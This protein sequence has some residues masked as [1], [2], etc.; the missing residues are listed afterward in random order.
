MFLSLLLRFVITSFSFLLSWN[1]DWICLPVSMTD[2][3]DLPYFSL[4]WNFD[5]LCLSVSITDLYNFFNLLVFIFV[6]TEILTDYVH[7][8]QLQIY[9]TCLIYSFLFSLSLRFRLFVF[10]CFYYRFIWLVQFF[11]WT[12]IPSWLWLIWFTFFRFFT[13]ILYIYL[14]SHY[15]IFETQLI[16]WKH[17]FHQFYWSF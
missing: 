7:L 4:S 5:Y 2:L 16:S 6:I 11:I 14:I 17:H 12:Y 10:I 1:F 3:L 8:F 13:Q 9:T 15:Q